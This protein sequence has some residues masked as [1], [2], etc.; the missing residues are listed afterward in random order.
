M[1]PLG[2]LRSGL[3][4]LSRPTHPTGTLAAWL[5]FFGTQAVLH[6]RLRDE[7]SNNPI[8]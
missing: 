7:Q 4:F 5:S 1:I 8:K 3:I 2:P 6:L